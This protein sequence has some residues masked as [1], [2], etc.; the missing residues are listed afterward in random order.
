MI[1]RQLVSLLALQWCDSFRAYL[2]S[3]PGLFNSNHAI[4]IPCVRWYRATSHQRENISQKM[5]KCV[6]AFAGTNTQ[7]MRCMD[8][9]GSRACALNA[10]ELPGRRL[11]D[12]AAMKQKFRWQIGETWPASIFSDYAD[13][14]KLA[15]FCWFSGVYLVLLQV[16]PESTLRRAKRLR[17]H[18]WTYGAVG[19]HPSWQFSHLVLLALSA[20]HE[21]RCQWL[22]SP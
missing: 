15:D 8:D 22:L 17:S 16:Y 10:S 6:V 5:Q 1:P 13:L 9:L 14:S 20:K 11:V 7:C 2:A 21:P 19:S 4:A 12:R 18:A 3:G